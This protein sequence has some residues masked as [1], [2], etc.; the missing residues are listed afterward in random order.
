[1]KKSKLLAAALLLMLGA[2]V[3]GP[4]VL[5][6][7]E[8]TEVW[9]PAPAMVAPRGYPLPPSDAIVLFDGKDLGEWRAAADAAKPANWIV[10]KGV[11]TV[12]A[13]AGPIASKRL[14]TDFQLHLE[15]RTPAGTKGA[16]QQRGNS[17][18]FLASTGPGDQGYEVQVLACDG[19]RTYANGKAGS[20]FKQHIPLANACAA[21]DQWQSYDIVWTAPRF[22]P[23]GALASPAYVTVLHN[24]VLIQNHVQL[25]GETVYQGPP[26]YRAHGPAPLK[27]QDHGDA[28]DF[29]NIWI[30]PLA[31]ATPG[32]P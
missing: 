31:A 28:V 26:G 14:F 6:A 7:P 4:K 15:W 2:C 5:P 27:L 23:D 11:L 12:R 30:R 9:E 3:S 18:V 8:T 32:T 24:G 25:G 21:G 16:G 13:G 17:G 20:V 29:R 10:D 22:K 1:M 19:N